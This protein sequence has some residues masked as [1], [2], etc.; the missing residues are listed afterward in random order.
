LRLL[1]VV[2]ASR[3]SLA[4]ASVTVAIMA[5]APLA[6]LADWDQFQGDPAHNGLSDGPSAPLTVAWTNDDVELEGAVTTGGLSSPI[7][8]EDGMIVVVAPT[9]VFGFDGADGSQTF[10]VDRDFGPSTQPAIA[11][12]PD[13]PIVVFTEGFGDNPPTAT[14]SGTPSPSPAQQDGDGVFDSHVNAVDMR[15]G[16]PVWGSPVQLE[17]VVQTPVAVDDSAAYIGDV[18][19]RVTSVDLR[20]GEVRWVVELGTSIAGAVSLDGDRAFVATLGT[21]GTPG[22]VVALNASTGDEVWRTD[23]DTMLGNLVSAPVLGDGRVLLLEPGLVVALDPDDGSPLWRT[24]IVN[25][26]TTPFTLRGVEATAPVSAD[27]QVVVVDVSGRMYALDAETGTELWDQA[28]NDPSGGSP[29]ILTDRQVLVP[30]DSGTLYAVDRVTGHLVFRSEARGLF[31]RGLADAGD[32]LVGVMGFDDAGVVA[33]EAEPDG[34]LI[35]EPSPTTVDLGELFAGFVAGALPV[36]VLAILIARPLQ[37]RRG[38][39]AATDPAIEGV[40]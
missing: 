12:G 22:E 2:R 20:S 1:R 24:E 26:R 7:V 6:A 30:A 4:V 37:R 16:E 38:P 17:D 40:E 36:G 15:T 10:T 29:P 14:G 23:E 31:L 11:S 35:D 3:R 33:F 21:Q 28:L 18:G 32:R 13:G 8:A 5:G 27:G 34:A 9:A 39:P 25:P 19:G